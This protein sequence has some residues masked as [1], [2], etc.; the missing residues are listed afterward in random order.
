MFALGAICAYLILQKILL[1]TKT[2]RPNQASW[3]FVSCYIAGYLGA[4]IFAMT[5]EEQGFAG[6]GDFFTRLSTFGA[7]TFYGGFLGSWMVGLIY[8]L[9]HKINIAKCA[10]AAVT[11]GMAALAI[12]RVGCFLNGDDYGVPVPSLYRDAWWAV[13]FPNHNDPTPRYPVQLMEA[14]FVMGLTMLAYWIVRRR[15]W[16]PGSVAMGLVTC[17]SVFR[18]GIEYLRGDP[19][20]WVSLQLLTPSQLVSIGLLMICN[21]IFAWRLIAAKK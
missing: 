16:K 11:A 4:R 7:M 21:V 15:F 10:D 20:G 3:F 12:G 6:V 1:D 9:R 5:V 8:C 17:Y 2:M 13:S 14:F 19:R 18:F